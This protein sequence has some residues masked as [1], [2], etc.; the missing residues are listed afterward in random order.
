MTL[1]QVAVLLAVIGF[2][3]G[4]A[5]ARRKSKKPRRQFDAHVHGEAQIGIVRDAN[6]IQIELATPAEGIFGFEHQPANDEQKN[7]LKTQK[8]KLEAAGLKFVK[9]DAQYGCKQESVDLDIQLAQIRRS[10]KD[11]RRGVPVKESYKGH[12]DVKAIFVVSCS[13]GLNGAKAQVQVSHLFPRVKKT[14]ILY[15]SDK[16]QSSN[17]ITSGSFQ[18]NL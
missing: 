3:S 2:F 6:S 13:K 12:G 18:L 8:A 4:E 7:I 15:L 16:R 1:R 9:I 11:E 10:K 17:V 14:K 5:D